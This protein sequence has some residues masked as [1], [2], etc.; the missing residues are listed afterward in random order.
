MSVARGMNDLFAGQTVRVTPAMIAAQVE[1]QRRRR[2]ARGRDWPVVN[3]VR[4]VG[5]VWHVKIYGCE[6]EVVIRGDAYNLTDYPRFA[7]ACE[8]QL[9][10]TFQPM[11]PWQ[12]GEWI[13]MLNDRWLVSIERRRA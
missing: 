11:K 5:P 10:L 6:R 7:R 4:M 2:A 12:T 8:E 1:E 3:R 9:G 13:R